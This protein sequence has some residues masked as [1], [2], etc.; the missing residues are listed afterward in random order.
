MLAVLALMIAAP[1][2]ASSQ[3]SGPAILYVQESTG[4]HFVQFSNFARCEA[5]RRMFEAENAEYRRN[6]AARGI[7]MVPGTEPIYRCIPG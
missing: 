5:A 1:V 4:W 6:A 3:P 7:Q 2:G